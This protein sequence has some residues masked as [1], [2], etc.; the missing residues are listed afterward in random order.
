MA[1]NSLECPICLDALKNPVATPCGHLSCETCLKSHVRSS[2]D[3]IHANCPTCRAT[4]PIVS[5]DLSLVPKKYHMFISPSVRRVYVDPTNEEGAETIENLSEKVALLEARVSS[6]QREKRV[7]IERCENAF[8]ASRKHQ[9][10]EKAARLV[11]EEAKKEMRAA[12][13]KYDAMKEKYQG[14]KTQCVL[15][16]FCRLS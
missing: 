10:G 1:S 16:S 13:K 7:L 2:P 14:V 8:H 11:A 12:H 6:L 4:F 9:E 5:P 3:P 15:V